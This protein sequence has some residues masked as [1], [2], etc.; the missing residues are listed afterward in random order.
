MITGLILLVVY[1]IVVGIVI[2]LL[3]YLVNTIPMDEPFR[4]VA[5]IVIVVIG[6][7]ICILLLLNFVGLI[8]AGMPRLGRP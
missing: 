6:V 1:L 5:N 8:D 3:H 4:R 2:W 7:L